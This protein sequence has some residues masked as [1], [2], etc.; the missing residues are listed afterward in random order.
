MADRSALHTEFCDLVGIEHPILNVGFGLGAGP[1]LAAAASNA[2]G[3]GEEWEAAG[4]PSS[5]S[6]PGEGT[7]IGIDHRPWGDVEIKRYAPFM[8][9]SEFEGA[10]EFAPLWAGESCELVHEI[11]PAGEIVRDLVR[12]AEQILAAR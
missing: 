1:A 3:C 11:K 2:G 7:S 8:V 4:R 12:E 6:R 9:S 5:G 10:S